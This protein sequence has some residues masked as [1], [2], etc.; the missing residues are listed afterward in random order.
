MFGSK[1]R[2]GKALLVER[3]GIGRVVEDDSQLFNLVVLDLFWRPPFSCFGQFFEF[4]VT[5]PEPPGLWQRTARHSPP[6][7]HVWRQ[8]GAGGQVQSVF[9]AHTAHFSGQD[10][11]RP[12]AWLAT[13]ECPTERRLDRVSHRTTNKTGTAYCS[14]SIED[15][16]AKA[17][18]KAEKA[19]S[20]PAA[21]SRAEHLFSC[22][23]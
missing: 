15:P 9:H 7:L 5:R 1:S 11:P 14:G 16:I 8:S 21:A 2:A 19:R 22:R 6:R 10:T 23:H 12:R 20:I 17:L 3:T 4:P 18:S 13:P